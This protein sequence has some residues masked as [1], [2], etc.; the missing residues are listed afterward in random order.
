MSIPAA[1]CCVTC[2]TLVFSAMGDDKGAA[3]TPLSTRKNEVLRKKKKNRA[4]C[5]WIVAPLEN[6]NELAARLLSN[7]IC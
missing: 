7:A 4:F 3:S 5:V 6:H 2:C 1:K